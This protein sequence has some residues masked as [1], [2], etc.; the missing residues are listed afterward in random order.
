[1]KSKAVNYIFP[2]SNIFNADLVPLF[3]SMDKEHSC[4]LWSTL[5][6]NAYEVISSYGSNF[7]L[8]LDEKDKEFLPSKLSAVND[9]IFY[10]NINDRETLLRNLYEK[11]FD[12]SENNI[13][14]FSNSICY[15]NKDITKTLNLLNIN[16]DALVLAKSAGGRICFAGFNTYPDF[17][18]QKDLNYDKVLAQSCK[19]NS[20]I[21][22]LDNFISVDT[23]NDF[24]KL[25]FELSKKES[26]AYCSQ[27]MHELFTHLFIEYK[28][29][30][31]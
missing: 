6:L 12:E 17:L 10:G 18:E 1:M 26:T 31:K 23:V 13:L 4:I 16:D 30:L 29:L 14:F 20:Y 24:K 2:L 15:T 22:L 9:K 28:E 5:Y 25:Y 21:Y 7:I 27:E 19:Y 8:L 3:G 11:F